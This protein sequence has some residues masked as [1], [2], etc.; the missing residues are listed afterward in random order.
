MND[1]A[2]NGW[3]ALIKIIAEGSIYMKRYIRDAYDECIYIADNGREY[4]FY[5]DFDREPIRILKA[6]DED[7]R[8]EA[9]KH[10]QQHMDSVDHMELWVLIDRDEIYFERYSDFDKYLKMRLSEGI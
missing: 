5:K 8:N 7:T 3:R 1:G 4:E 9:I 6:L 2:N 10:K